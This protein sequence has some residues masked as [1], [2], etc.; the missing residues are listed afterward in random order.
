M[1]AAEIFSE[2]AFTVV[3]LNFGSSPNFKYFKPQPTLEQ[4]S[5]TTCQHCAKPSSPHCTRG[6][7]G[8]RLPERLPADGLLIL[9]MCVSLFKAIYRDGLRERAG[10]QTVYE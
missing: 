5:N 7:S 10:L 1:I 9:L 3:E 6:S 4:I 8:R 2:A